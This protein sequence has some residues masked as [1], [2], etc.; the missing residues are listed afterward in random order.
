MALVWPM[1][2]HA[3]CSGRGGN[4]KRYF[5]GHGLHATLDAATDAALTLHKA[6]ELPASVPR[7]KWLPSPPHVRLALVGVA[8]RGSLPIAHRL[9]EAHTRVGRGAAAAAGRRGGGV[10]ARLGSGRGRRRALAAQAHS[11]RQADTPEDLMLRGL[12]PSS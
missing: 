12:V 2:V 1:C 3:S 5:P 6:A 8:E 4:D 9:G 11:R 10:R 7:A